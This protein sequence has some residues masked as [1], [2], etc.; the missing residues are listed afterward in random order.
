MWRIIRDIILL[1]LGPAGWFILVIIYLIEGNGKS[2]GTGWR[3]PP[4]GD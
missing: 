4:S 1:L 2:G 3:N